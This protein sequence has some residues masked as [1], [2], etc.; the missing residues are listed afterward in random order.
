MEGGNGRSDR[1]RFS[2]GA[3]APGQKIVRHDQRL[4][5]AKRKMPE[6]DGRQRLQFNRWWRRGE[7]VLRRSQ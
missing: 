3:A 2:S 7:E 5:T 6:M 1:Q 4:Y